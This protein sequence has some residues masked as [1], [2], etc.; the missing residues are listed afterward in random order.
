MG[1]GAGR[2]FRGP[3]R[4]RPALLE[5]LPGQDCI[6]V[7]ARAGP[8]PLPDEI[9]EAIT[10]LTGRVFQ[11]R[12]SPIKPRSASITPLSS[13]FAMCCSIPMNS[14]TLTRTAGMSSPERAKSGQSTA[15]LTVFAEDSHRLQPST[16]REGCKAGRIRRP[17]AVDLLS[18]ELGAW[19]EADGTR[20]VAGGTMASDGHRAECH[21]PVHGRR[22]E[23]H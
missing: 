17:G 10:F 8:S 18:C 20:F 6:R 19:S 2:G 12:A 16:R 1:A 21:F 23:P 14:F 7:P 11:R 13:T 4:A 22:T 9:A 3:A 15:D 5:R